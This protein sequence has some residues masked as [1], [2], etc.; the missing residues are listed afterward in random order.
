M[1]TPVLWNITFS[2]I[3]EAVHLHSIKVNDDQMKTHKSVQLHVIF[4][5]MYLLNS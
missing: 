1:I 2:R 4:G 5:C 3:S